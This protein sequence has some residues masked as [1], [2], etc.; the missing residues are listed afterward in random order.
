MILMMPLPGLIEGKQWGRWGVSGV[1]GVKLL[2]AND[3]IVNVIVE[4]DVIGVIV[5]GVSDVIVEG[6]VT[7]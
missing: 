1:Y 6:L 7:S 5:A 3:V 2:E 4:D